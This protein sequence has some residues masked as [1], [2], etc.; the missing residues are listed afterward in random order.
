MPENQRAR[1]NSNPIAHPSTFTFA[2][3]HPIKGAKKIKEKVVAN[4]INLIIAKVV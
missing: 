1:M 3:R 2:I 4:K